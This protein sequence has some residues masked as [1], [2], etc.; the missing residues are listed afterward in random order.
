MADD[1]DRANE[2]AELLRA[3]AEREAREWQE[4]QPGTGLC[5]NCGATIGGTGRWCNAECRDDHQRYTKG[6]DAKT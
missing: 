6:H 4:I 5:M 3:A 2:T 1:I